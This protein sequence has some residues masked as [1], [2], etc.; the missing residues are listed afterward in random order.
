MQKGK[1]YVEVEFLSDSKAKIATEEIGIEAD[2]MSRQVLD[3]IIS[4]QEEGVRAKDITILAKNGKDITDIANYFSDYRNT[5]K[6][7]IEENGWNLDIISDEAYMLSS[8]TALTMLIDAMKVCI[9]PYDKI[10]MLELYSNYRQIT[11]TSLE[12]N[13]TLG[14]LHYEEEPEYQNLKTAVEELRNLPLYEM[15]EELVSLLQ[16]E[17]LENESSFLFTFM[18]YMNEFVSRKSPDLSRFLEYWDKYLCKKKIPMSDGSDGIHIMTIHKSKGLEFHTVIVPYCDWNIFGDPHH[19]PL[20]WCDTHDIAPYNQ[21]PIVPV[22]FDKSKLGET[23]FNEEFREEKIE[24]LVDSINLLYVAFTRAVNNLLILCYYS[25]A[26]ELKTVS[27]LLDKL[28]FAPNANCSSSDVSEN[29]EIIKCYRNGELIGSTSSET[30]T[31]ESEGNGNPF[32]SHAKAIP[33]TFHYNKR[34]ATFR[35]SNKADEYIQGVI[36]AEADKADAR[37][38]GTVVSRWPCSS[39]ST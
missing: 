11:D 26:K 7:R 39:S 15:A 6:D 1:G 25:D 18:D 29:E 4:L 8:S 23:I 12:F 19:K 20:L 9:Q 24:Q 34:R 21:L 35:N 2:L 27:Q 22:E 10:S 3:K 13:D 30:G 16:L 28:I 5:Y 31:E 37:K 32:K 38:R 14:N 36:E 17:K 33:C